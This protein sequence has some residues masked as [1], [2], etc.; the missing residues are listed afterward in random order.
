MIISAVTN[1]CYSQELFLTSEAASSE[2]KDRKYIILNTDVVS[3]GRSYTPYYGMMYGISGRVT[4]MGKE[5]YSRNPSESFLGDID[6]GTNWR[7]LSYDRKQFHYR[8][9]LMTHIR[10]PVASKQKIPDLSSGNTS[11]NE[12]YTKDF[13]DQ[14][15][16]SQYKTDNW[17]PY[18]GI[19]ATF[20]NKKF[21]ANIQLNYGV[22]I[23]KG[24]YKFGNYFL[25]G[26]AFGYLL[27]PK[28]YKSYSD[29]NVN[30]YIE[31]KL[32]HFNENEIS[33]T[34]KL[35]GSGGWKREFTAGVQL[36]IAST[37][38][39]ELG[40]TYSTTDA[41]FKTEKN[42]FFTSLKYLFF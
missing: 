8:M 12:S 14:I 32:Y 1:L 18:G 6:L 4:F 30:L 10:I 33:G 35:A 34:G 24:D 39:I 28:E 25:G 13:K 37:S 36:I 16:T 3:N 19:A 21:A 26:L 42:V 17:T 11:S 9:S 22:P 27:F 40:Y 38:L 29:L 5:Y 23:S 15:L 7:F 31:P 2:A 41:E 20:L